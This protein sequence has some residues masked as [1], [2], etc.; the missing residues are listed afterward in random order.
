MKTKQ[1]PQFLAQDSQGAINQEYDQIRSMGDLGQL[2]DSGLISLQALARAT[3]TDPNDT[4][5]GAINA[6][7][8]EKQNRYKTWEDQQVT[9]G[10]IPSFARSSGYDSQWSPWFE[11]LE[12]SGQRLTGKPN[13]KM[14]IGGAPGLPTDTSAGTLPLSMQGLPGAS[15]SYD[16]F[17]FPTGI[18]AKAKPLTKEQQDAQRKAAQPQPWSLG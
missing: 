1:A 2:Q 12:E 4:S 16:S 10:T 17:G 14:V 15:Y 9:K 7:A 3:N 18:A 11:A 13:P 6:R 5:Q 8:Q